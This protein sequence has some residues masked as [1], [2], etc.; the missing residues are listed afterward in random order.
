VRPEV[1]GVRE[2]PCHRYAVWSDDVALVA[3]TNENINNL[4]NEY[5]QFVV[6]MLRDMA[7]RLRE[8][9]KLID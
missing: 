9:N 2:T 3:I 4:M 6:E 5:P 8:T 7:K 1:P